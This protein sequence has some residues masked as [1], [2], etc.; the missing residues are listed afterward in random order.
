MNDHGPV[1]I[2]NLRRT[3]LLSTLAASATLL[4]VSAGL[5]LQSGHADAANSG[6]RTQAAASVSS[7]LA[8]PGPGWT[9]A[10]PQTSIVFRGASAAQLRPVRVTGSR[11]GVHEGSL[12]SSR[13]GVGAVFTPA[14]PFAPGEHVTVTSA[15]PVQG[16]DSTTY[17]F[18]VAIPVHAPLPP[19]EPRDTNTRTPLKSK[20]AA[21]D[22]R[23]CVPHVWHFRTR[24]NMHPAAAC[25]SRPATGTADGL[26]FT[27][28]S[29]TSFHQ[30][31]PTI[32]DQ[33][34][35]V[36]W[37]HP[38]AYKQIYDLSVVTYHGQ[39]LLAFH[40]RHR[41][42]TTGYWHASVLLYNRH[43]QLV[44]RVTAQNGY[45][46][47]G[48]EFQ[49]RGDAAWL[50]A[51]NPIIDPVS[52][53]PVYE[54]VVQKIDI[55]TGE[56]LFE[57]HSLPEIET[58]YSYVP[59]RAGEVWD[60]FHGN[61]IDPLPDGG[62]LLSSR[63]TSS[64]YQISAT[65]DVLWTMGGKDDGFGITTL[66]PSWQFCFQHDVRAVGPDQLTVFDNGGRG[67]GC[68]A[69]KARVEGFTYDPATATAKRTIKYSSYNAS[70][71]G[72]GYRVS[73]LGS[74]RYLL[75]GDLMVS[76]GTAGRIT[77][78]TPGHDVDFDLTLAVK[79]YR[80]DRWRWVGDPTERPAVAASRA[81]GR[82]N[83]YASWNGSTR[84]I[85]WRVLAG[86]SRA[87]MSPI[88]VRVHRTGFETH[89]PVTTRARYVAVR[90]I[91]GSGRVLGTSAVIK[92]R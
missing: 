10:S 45:E 75:N 15:Q 88:G 80:A 32:F 57:W 44:A 14:Q 59:P 91:G 26:I 70:S 48:H 66:H 90:A 46:V 19:P 40:V 3:R 39:R 35:N 61:A 12:V 92:P 43:Y 55:A 67:P 85:R 33:Q 62:F 23:N 54:Y 47:D 24:P 79:T 50:G 6:P 13:A 84:V 2:L 49:V 16:A 78:F 1:T 38:M 65:G 42:G 76:W 87:Q 25:V 74:A 63:N 31:G 28:P 71:D 89:I 8:Y 20:A 37:Y 51:Y 9:T 29:P 30:H 53:N 83:V 60:Y 22:V 34:G 21:S 17:T 77:E 27:T 68:P 18:G 5:P 36:V 41:R 4:L 81:G 86:P 56:V 69:H 72:R 52:G 11:T 82:V 73:A 7:V 58:S 64:V